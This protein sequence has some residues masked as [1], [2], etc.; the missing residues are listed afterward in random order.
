MSKPHEQCKRFSHTKLS[1]IA[2]VLLIF[3]CSNVIPIPLLEY[4]IAIQNSKTCS[5]LSNTQVTWWC[6]LMCM[7]EP[8]LGISC[9]R[10]VSYPECMNRDLSFYFLSMMK[11]FPP[12]VLLPHL[13][14]HQILYCA[15]P[16]ETQ[17]AFLLWK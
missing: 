11:C 3:Q 4:C 17:L 16:Q 12:I 8:A 15:A 9:A 6:W 1:G 13:I 10:A 7:H 5:S 2:Q 14:A